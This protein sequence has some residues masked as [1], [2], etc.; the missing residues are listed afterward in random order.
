M[1]DEASLAASQAAKHELKKTND[2][3]RKRLSRKRI[4]EKE[5]L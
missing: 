5:V 4:K 1:D 2:R 3:D